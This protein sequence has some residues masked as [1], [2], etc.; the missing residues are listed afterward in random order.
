MTILLL[1]PY[2]TYAQG[3]T[4]DLDNATEASL[5]AQGRATYTVNPGSAFAPLT[6]VEQQDLRDG[7]AR[8]TASQTTALQAL[9]AGTGLWANRPASPALYDQYFATD[10]GPNGVQFWWNGSR[11]K[12]LFASVIAETSTLVAGVAQT[13]DQYFTAARL[14]PFPLGLLGVGDV[15]QYHIGL[16]KA[17]TTD[18]F[19][20]LSIRIG[21]NGAIGDSA[22]LQATISSFMTAASRSGG[23]E[24]W[25]R[26]ESATTIRGLGVNNA[27]SS[28]NNV[29][30]S[31]TAAD[32]TQ[33]IPNIT[34]VPLYIGLSTTMSGATDAPQIAYQRLT[35]LP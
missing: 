26:I 5:V 35:L 19:T 31:G 20:A 15:L 29:N 9:V 2:A 14:G 16:G 12:V 28:W 6:A 24:K 10:I 8:L 22:V 17:G 18:T 30:I 25:M 33:T 3:A 21:Q 13:A 4:V 34:S 32:S 27:N 7:A 1:R 23:I 11:W